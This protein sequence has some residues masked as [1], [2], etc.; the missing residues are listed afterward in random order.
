M[1]CLWFCESR[2]CKHFY[3]KSPM[4]LQQKYRTLVTCNAYAALATTLLEVLLFFFSAFSNSRVGVSLRNSIAFFR[5]YCLK[6]FAELTS[7]VQILYWHDLFG[8]LPCKNTEF[9]GITWNNVPKTWGLH[10]LK[11]YRSWFHFCKALFF[12]SFYFSRHSESGECLWLGF[13]S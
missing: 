8:E 2:C 13:L 9:A 1:K 10:S 7:K 3:M 6:T 11:C 4:E 5:F 12:Q